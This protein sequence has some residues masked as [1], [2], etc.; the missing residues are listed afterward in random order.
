MRFNFS[1]RNGKRWNPHAL[2]TL[3][4]FSPLL[5]PLP[6]ALF[7]GYEEG[8]SPYCEAAHIAPSVSGIAAAA[9]ERKMSFLYFPQLNLTSRLLQS[10]G[11]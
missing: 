2:I 8:K 3:V 4:L 7:W 10:G 9:T 6:D 11:Y 1:V 5:R